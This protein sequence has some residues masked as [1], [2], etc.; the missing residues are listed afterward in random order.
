[1]KNQTNHILIN[2]LSI[3]LI[4][5]LLLTCHSVNGQ[6]KF[7]NKTSIALTFEPNAMMYFTARGNHFKVTE[8]RYGLT[9]GLFQ[10]PDDQYIAPDQL[11]T[12][13]STGLRFSSLC[14]Y[15]FFIN[16]GML[17]H[18]EYYLVGYNNAEAHQAMSYDL[19]E[20]FASY[21]RIPVG[22]S[23]AF[24]SEKKV[25]RSLGIAFNFD[26]LMEDKV[27]Y[28]FAPSKGLFTKSYPLILDRIVPELAYSRTSKLYKNLFLKLELG[29]CFAPVFQKS[30]HEFI[31]TNNALGWRLMLEYRQKENSEND[32]KN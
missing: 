13:F 27:H 20:Y 10:S 24:N 31:I 14:I 28:R 9:S 15:N 3:I 22:I 5:P 2:K 19:Y 25:K 26:F 30:H 21:I 23:R 8:W 12:N 7:L 11:H 32:K 18:H 1:M 4:L 17:Y 6:Y 29:Y 16:S